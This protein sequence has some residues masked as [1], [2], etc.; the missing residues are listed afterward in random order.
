[1]RGRQSNL[2]ARDHLLVTLCQV[3]GLIDPWSVPA[4]PQNLHD[5]IYAD[6][7]VTVSEYALQRLVQHSLDDRLDSAV[8]TGKPNGADLKVM[9]SVMARA[10]RVAVMRRRLLLPVPGWASNYCRRLLPAAQCSWSRLDEALDRLEGA[11]GGY[12]QHFLAA[13]VA[14]ANHDGR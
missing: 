11:A 1:M 5:L 13:L 12:K 2:P 7:K 14:V 9:L 6:N 8:R 10:G 4:V 3:T